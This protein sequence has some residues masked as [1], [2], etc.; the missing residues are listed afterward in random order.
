[1]TTNVGFTF[2]GCEFTYD[3]H[4]TNRIGDTKCN[5]YYGHGLPN[6]DH[7][8]CDQCSYILSLGEKR[9]AVSSCFRS[10]S[11]IGVI[12]SKERNEKVI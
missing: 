5:I 4:M 1:M 2:G 11:E 10:S 7:G 3:L 9:V 6:P 12:M 8:P